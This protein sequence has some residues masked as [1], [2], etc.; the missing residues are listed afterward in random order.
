MMFK[1]LGIPVYI[2]DIEA[3]KLTNRSKIIKRKLLQLLG[4][5]SYKDGILNRTFVADK[6]FNNTELLQ[7]VN[8]IIHPKVATHFNRWIK[9]QDALY[10]IK[11]AAILFEN[12]G[13]D[14]CDLTIL[15]VAPKEVRIGRILKR[16]TTTKLEIESRMSHQWSDSEK[17][18]L[19]DIIIEN[20]SLDN[21]K[22]QVLRIHKM[23]A[24][25][26]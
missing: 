4:P 11:E 5:E 1:E 6:I 21:T 18:K 8:N 15:V 12:G 24:E 3:K 26:R 25:A 23:L 10:C 19:A 13:Y 17:K 14:N 2:A 20:T 16:D 9:K 22:K 7:Q